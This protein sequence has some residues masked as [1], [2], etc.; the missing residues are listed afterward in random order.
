MHPKGRIDHAIS[1]AVAAALEPSRR[2]RKRAD[3]GGSDEPY[4]SIMTISS[5]YSSVLARTT[6]I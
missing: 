1:E 4:P 5:R 6:G 3:S 2:H